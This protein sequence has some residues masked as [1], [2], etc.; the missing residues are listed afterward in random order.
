MARMSL[1]VREYHFGAQSVPVAASLQA[2]AAIMRQTGRLEDA[3]AACRRC[4]KIR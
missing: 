1:E 3:E 2:L 4:I